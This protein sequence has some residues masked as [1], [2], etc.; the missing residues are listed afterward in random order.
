MIVIAS[1]LIV[2]RRILFQHK[3]FYVISAEQRDGSQPEIEDI[4]PY[5][6]E[7]EDE[8]DED[9]DEAGSGVDNTEFITIK[10][11]NTKGE[12]EKQETD[13]IKEHRVVKK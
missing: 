4:V 13:E 12:V 11:T 7:Q 3:F 8:D 1:N 9:S 6:N 10:V 2:A 5:E